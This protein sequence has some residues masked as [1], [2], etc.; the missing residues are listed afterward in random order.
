MLF[1]FFEEFDFAEVASVLEAGYSN[2]LRFLKG[3]FKKGLLGL[4]TQTRR[5]N[6]TNEQVGEYSPEPSQPILLI[7][8]P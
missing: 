2:D 7:S 4:W 6:E 1:A 8:F 3:G 5:E